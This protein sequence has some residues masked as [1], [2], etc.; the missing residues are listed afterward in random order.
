MDGFPYV[1]NENVVGSHKDYS[2]D[3]NRS[4]QCVYFLGT[5]RLQVM[6]LTMA[7]C[8]LMMRPLPVYG[9]FHNRYTVVRADL[10]K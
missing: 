7:D 6:I 2:K 9:Y 8:S 1:Q 5:Q 3:N 4:A 10:K